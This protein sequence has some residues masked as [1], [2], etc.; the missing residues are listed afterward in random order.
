MQRGREERQEC[1]RP[2]ASKRVAQFSEIGAPALDLWPSW[3]PRSD[4]SWGRSWGGDSKQDCQPDKLV[5]SG[6]RVKTVPLLF[7]MLVTPRMKVSPRRMR[8]ADCFLTSLL[9]ITY[10]GFQALQEFYPAGTRVP[11]AK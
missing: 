4:G 2:R 7:Y 6:L 9:L 10:G 3:K 5:C 8:Q 11:L 1:S